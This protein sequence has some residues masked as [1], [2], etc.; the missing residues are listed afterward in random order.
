MLRDAADLRRAF[1][2]AGWSVL[3]LK[4]N[5]LTVEGVGY[6]VTNVR[7][8]RENLRAFVEVVRD[9]AE[10][11]VADQFTPP[12]RWPFLPAVRRVENAKV[13]V[14][15]E[16]FGRAQA[17]LECLLSALT[18]STQACASAVSARGWRVVRETSPEL[19]YWDQSWELLAE[20]EGESLR[21][22]LVSS[23]VGRDEG[24]TESSSS[25]GTAVSKVGGSS[26]YVTVGCA[27]EA[28]ELASALTSRA[29]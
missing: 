1:A 5:A 12:P 3:W 20:R 4:E 19:T 9:C 11:G 16:D 14:H 27:R 22:G 24:I 28:S 15:V 23:A 18:R 13:T 8:N 29:V 2:Q 21:I 6:D 25:S 10:G 17:E 26:A 7:A